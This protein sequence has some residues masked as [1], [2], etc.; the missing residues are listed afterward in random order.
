MTPRPDGPVPRSPLFDL[1]ARVREPSL[2]ALVIAHRGDS[3]NAPENTLAAFALALENGADAVEF[4]VQATADDALVVLHDERLDRT[5]DA[6][7]EVAALPLSAVREASAGA[8][9][10]A[11]FARERVPTLDETLDLLSGRAVPLIEVKVK[12]R[13]AA[14]AARAV[15]EALVRHGLEERAVVICRSR[16]QVAGVRE[17]SPR[18]PIAYLALTRRQAL[19]ALKLEGVRGADIYWKSVSL[20]LVQRFRE[21]S[22]FLTPW[23]VNR[24]VDMDRLLL[25]GAEAIISDSP[26]LLRD[27]IERFEFERSWELAE[28]FRRGESELGAELAA[29]AEEAEAEDLESSDIDLG[30]LEEP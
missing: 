14:A 8:W 13:R 28:R 4:D 6:K 5:T 7:G 12:K 25:L 2:E 23:T 3:M 18:T 11:R 17:G 29:E 9:F 19:G 22:A 16:A 27:R 20:A 10:D 1:V 30:P 21:L 24:A 15:G 26:L